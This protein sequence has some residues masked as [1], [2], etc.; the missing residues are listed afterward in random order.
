[1]MVDNARILK[2]VENGLESRGE[3]AEQDILGVEVNKVFE[4]H[5]QL[6]LV[7][8]DALALSQLSLDHVHEHPDLGDL[9]LEVFLLLVELSLGGLEDGVFHLGGHLEG[10]G[11]L[12]LRVDAESQQFL[13]SIGQHLLVVLGVLV[14][15]DLLVVLRVVDL[16]LPPVHQDVLGQIHLGLADPR[17]H[18][19]V[20]RRLQHL[21]VVVG[22]ARLVHERLV[23]H[24]AAVDHG[25]ERGVF[26][27]H[28]TEQEET[29][30]LILPAVCC[31]VARLSRPSCRPARL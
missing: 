1:M 4:I 7:P 21:A 10:A 17:G 3:L 5:E 31:R 24:R 19:V 18:E 2:T 12:Q 15:L 9:G 30:Y 6:F 25:V 29:Q 28:E 14:A 20:A 27:E 16:S 26:R 22:E 11:S 23:H 8:V 13:V